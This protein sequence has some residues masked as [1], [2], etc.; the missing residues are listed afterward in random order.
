VSQ[1][2][3]QEIDALETVTETLFEF[4][5]GSPAE[6]HRRRMVAPRRCV[7]TPCPP[8]PSPGFPLSRGEEDRPLRCE[9]LEWTLLR[10]D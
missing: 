7:L 2:Q 5:E 3:F 1:R 8:L 10:V 4:G 9:D 6:G